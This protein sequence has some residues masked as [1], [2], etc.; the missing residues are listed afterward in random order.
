MAKKTKYLQG[1]YIPIN[2]EKYVGKKAPKYRSSWELIF[3]KVLDNNPAVLKWGSEVI[4]IPY[5]DPITG[6]RTVYIPDFIVVYQDADNKGHAE[7][8][9]IKPLK[10]SV[11]EKA[12]RSAANRLAV[13]KN[14]AKW[15]AAQAYCRA[16]GLQFKVYTENQLFA[17]KLKKRK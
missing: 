17:Q 3:M 7:V 10:E 11:M 1:R 16:N 8:I 15:Q 6:R 13:V 2:G 4:K 5:V 9:E 12:G 14:K